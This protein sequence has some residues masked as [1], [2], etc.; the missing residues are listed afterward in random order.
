M[1][2]QLLKFLASRN[3]KKLENNLS[4][5]KM[6]KVGEATM[7]IAQKYLNSDKTIS[8]R[9]VAKTKNIWLIKSH[10]SNLLNAVEILPHRIGL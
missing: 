2:K 9:R 6:A 10:S 5:R 3:R 1:Q 4:F 8:M 7:K